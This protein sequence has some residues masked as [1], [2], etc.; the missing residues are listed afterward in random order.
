[1]ELR[2]HLC[3]RSLNRPLTILGVERKVFFFLITLSVGLFNASGA[4]IPAV[5]MFAIL[6]ALARI[7]QAADPQ[8][9]RIVM[10]SSRFAVRYDPA[11]WTPTKGQEGG[12]DR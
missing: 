6:Y 7:G 12:Y 5:A 4:L 11:K 2:I 3:Y 8:M 1:M 10:N 9:L